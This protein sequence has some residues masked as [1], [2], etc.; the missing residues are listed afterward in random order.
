MK[1]FTK[2][3]AVLAAG[4]LLPLTAGASAAAPETPHPSPLR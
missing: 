4:T 3:F 1:L 2:L